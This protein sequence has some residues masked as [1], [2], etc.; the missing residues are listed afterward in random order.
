[1]KKLVCLVLTLALVLG[2]S[3]A[4]ALTI[5]FSQVGAESDWRTANTDDVCKAIE[6]AGWTLVYDDAQ[7]KQENQVKALRNFITQGV[8]YIVFTAVVTTGWDEVLQE[9]K[10]EGIPIVLIDRFPETSFEDDDWYTTYFG[11]DFPEEGRKA[12][13]WIYNYMESIGHEGDINIVRLSGTTG[14]DAQVGRTEGFDEIVAE[15]SNMKII[16]DQS[17]N[18]T[19]AEGQPVM[20]ACLK[21]VG[22]EN[23]DVVWAENDD[24][25]TG[26]IEAIKA[27]GFEP[28]K[29][30]IIVGC[31][32]V[33][34]A[35]DAIVSGEMN[36]TI[37]CT[38][39]MGSRVVEVITGLENG[40]TFEKTVHPVEYV[41]DCVGGIAY[42]DSGNVSILAA[43]VIDERVY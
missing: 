31:D 8:D 16:Y 25:A 18:F 41:Y 26:A 2:A 17:G 4:F 19:R 36:C 33:K 22:G 43:D 13:R 1:M 14:S 24:M 40:E 38:P 11:G 27:A 29:D 39:L 42:D 28:G 9:V 34:A 6:D 20:E 32:A 7:Q 3:S 21:A 12:A 35:F 5:G 30:I 15:N 10:D 37:E 23:I